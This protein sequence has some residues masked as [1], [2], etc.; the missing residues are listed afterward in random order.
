MK[1]NYKGNVQI[2][3]PDSRAESFTIACTTTNY[4]IDVYQRDNVVPS[5]IQEPIRDAFCRYPSSHAAPFVPTLPASSAAASVLERVGAKPRD[6][7]DTNLIEDVTDGTGQ[8]IDDPAQ[9]G[10]WP[11]LSS[12]TP[13]LDSDS[14]GTPD[15]WELAHSLNPLNADDRNGDL[16]GD[17][18]TNLEEF[19]NELAGDQ[20]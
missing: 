12:G 11:M 7:T 9:V 17:G 16:D 5:W 18:Y 20:G 6:S 19:L 10:G 14:D 3:G 4:S 8:I 13:P 15:S 2:S 1:V